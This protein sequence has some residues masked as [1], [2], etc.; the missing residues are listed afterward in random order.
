MHWP[1][2]KKKKNESKDTLRQTAEKNTN[3]ESQVK[4]LNAQLAQQTQ[5]KNQIETELAQARNLW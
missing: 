3:L 4:N 2:K 5:Q 1:K